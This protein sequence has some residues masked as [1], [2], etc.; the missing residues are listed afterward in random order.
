MGEIKECST[1]QNSYLSIS[2]KS[3]EINS[4]CKQNCFVLWRLVSA[5]QIG[6]KTGVYQLLGDQGELSQG[7]TL[8]SQLRFDAPNY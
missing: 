7:N 6:L 5:A 8:N 2:L 3:N 4:I 1:Q